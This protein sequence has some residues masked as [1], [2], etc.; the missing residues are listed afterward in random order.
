MQTQTAKAE[1]LEANT[2][3]D[4]A[5]ASGDVETI[6]QAEAEFHLV[7]LRMDSCA[8]AEFHLVGLQ[9]DSCAE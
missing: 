8:E 1:Y 7:W 6:T 4:M 5:I 9:M 3:L 2:T